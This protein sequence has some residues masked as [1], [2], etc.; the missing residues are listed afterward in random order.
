MRIEAFIVL[1]SLFVG[2]SEAPVVLLFYVSLA[3]CTRERC[4]GAETRIAVAIPTKTRAA[5]ARRCV[6]V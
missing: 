1:S 3:R 2:R 6:V 4:S 5:A